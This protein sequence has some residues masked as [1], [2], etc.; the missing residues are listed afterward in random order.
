[1]K[2][3][4]LSQ[5]L[6]LSIINFSPADACTA[7]MMSDGENVFVG[8]NEDYKIPYTRVWF[9]PAENEQYGRVYFGYDNWSPQGGMNDQG[10]F[11]DFFAVKKLDIKRSKEKPK[12]PGPMIDAMLAELS[13]VEEVLNMFGQ[14]NLEWMS[15]G[16]MFIVDKSGDAA[17]IE[18]DAVIRKTGSHQV[19]TNFRLSKIA[20]D[21]RP[22]RWPAWSC[23]RYKK[24]EKMLMESDEATVANFRD[25]LKATHRGPYN[26]LSRTL[27]SNIYD[28][29]RGLVYLYYL[30][31]FDNEV[32]LNLGEELKKGRHY[33]DLPSLF[34]KE[35]KYDRKVYTHR[36]PGFSISYPKHF[37]VIDPLLD[38]VLLVKYPISS[39][40]SFGVYVE[41]K[42]PDI[43]LPDIGQRFF[44][45]RVKKYSTSAKLVFSKQTMLIDGIPANEVLFERVVDDHWPLKT[46]ILA[47]YWGDKLIFAAVSSFEYPESL[48][49]YLYSLR[50]D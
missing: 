8:N 7:F 32:V 49:E 4:L 50:F 22:C 21:Q 40:P 18:G 20:E 16:Q 27:Y 37:K 28:L 13:T 1:M 19:V 48:R 15:K 33:Y 42:P 30:H 45:K 36:S 34:G 12:F 6:F 26:V 25:I 43:P 29:R 46:L 39:M 31:D 17:I 10:L 23:S 38:E 2:V 14:Y 24:A 5:I 11:F 47:T 35:K 44:S 41:N 9:F 3:L